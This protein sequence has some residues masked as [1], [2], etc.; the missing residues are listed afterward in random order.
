MSD[1]LYST[2]WLCQKPITAAASAAGKMSQ[3][4]RRMN[5]AS[6]SIEG[7]L[8]VARLPFAPPAYPLG[9]PTVKGGEIGVRLRRGQPMCRPERADTQVR[10]YPDRKGLPILT[11]RCYAP[12]KQT[13]SAENP[14]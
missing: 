7:A 4:Y 8:L 14:R 2:P 10:P 9:R 1:S 12:E 5:R 6:R 11:S 3:L 13:R